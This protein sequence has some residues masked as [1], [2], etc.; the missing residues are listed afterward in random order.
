MATEVRAAARHALLHLTN[1]VSSALP[2]TRAFGVRRILYRWSGIDVAETAQINGGVV[3]QY[4]NVRIGDRTWIGRGSSFAPTGQAPIQIG[5][6]CDISQEVLFVTG[7]HE[8]GPTTR[9]AGAGTSEPI[10][11]GAG[12]WIGARCLVLGGTIVG[13]GCVIAAGSILKGEFE[14][15]SLIAGAPA[16]RIRSA[17][18]DAHPLDDD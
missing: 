10:S 4:P 7:S 1:L 6:A 8:R 11:I 3:F 5:A 18:P 13:P 16:K 14:A 15:N 9:R 12:T 17:D 2:Q